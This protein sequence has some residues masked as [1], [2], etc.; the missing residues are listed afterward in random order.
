[1]KFKATIFSRSKA[2]YQ[3]HFWFFVVGGPRCRERN[4]TPQGASPSPHG[5]PATP[6]PEG[7]K[8]KKRTPAYGHLFV[9][10]C[11]YC[12]LLVSFVC[13]V[14]CSLFVVCLTDRLAY[15]YLDCCFEVYLVWG[16]ARPS[17][18]PRLP[19]PACAQST[20]FVALIPNQLTFLPMKKT[21]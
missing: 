13:F 18:S 6:R 12:L 4:V 7:E 17:A 9:F 8:T 1:M 2:L 11:A 21:K 20:L 15:E 14:S 3:S 5:T 10:L 19:H 16:R